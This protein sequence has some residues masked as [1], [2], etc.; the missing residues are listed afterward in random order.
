MALTEEQK[1]ERLQKLA[2]I[3]CTSSQV[4]L[5]VERLA[6]RTQAG[7]E[8]PAIAAKDDI[9]KALS[10]T[11][12]QRQ[13]YLAALACGESAESAETIAKEIVVPAKIDIDSS[14]NPPVKPE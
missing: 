11:D 12:H 13:A 7:E 8:A 5:F 4:K 6:A 2:G 14:V 1:Q 10:L 9:G 3:D